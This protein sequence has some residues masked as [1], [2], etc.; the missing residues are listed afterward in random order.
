MS[1][2]VVVVAWV[3]PSDF[4]ICRGVK[5]AGTDA[6]SQEL[7]PERSLCYVAHVIVDTDLMPASYLAFRL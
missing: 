2:I 3:S 1:R 7:R 4:T 6:V 5:I